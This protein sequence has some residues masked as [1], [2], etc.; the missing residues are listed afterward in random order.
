[1]DWKSHVHRCH[2]L[3]VAALLSGPAGPSHAQAP[4]R[5]AHSYDV[6]HLQM[7][8][9]WEAQPWEPEG[10]SNN[11]IVGTAPSVELR[12]PIPSRY[13]APGT[14]AR[15]YLVAPVAGLGIANPGSLEISWRTT[16][17]LASG[18][19]RA[20]Q[21]VIIFE[22][23]VPAPVIVDRFTYTVRMEAADVTGSF[24]LEP[25]FEIEPA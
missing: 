16:G 12:L 13:L 23:T 1:M 19:A 7:R 2:Y 25:T 5:I 4:E 18:R 11:R 22:G 24:E 20:G 15:I 21:R 8:A 14:R 3:A 17:V 9:R 10:K 6:V